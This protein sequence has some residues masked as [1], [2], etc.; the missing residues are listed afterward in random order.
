MDDKMEL[1]LGIIFLLAGIFVFYMIF[2]KDKAEQ[3]RDKK[4][5][6]KI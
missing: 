4:Q 1:I 3:G 2:K 5:S 6:P